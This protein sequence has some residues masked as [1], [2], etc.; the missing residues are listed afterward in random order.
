MTKILLVGCGKMGGALLAGW[1]NRGVAAA[2]V[3]V[4]EPNPVS[5]LPAGLRQV[6]DAAAI[7]AD[8]VPDIVMLAV[9]PQAMDQAAPAYARYAGRACFL[10]IA[11]GKTIAGLNALLG[12]NAAIVRSMPNTPAAV[13][14]GITVC[15]ASATVST[16]QRDAC[17]SR[18]HE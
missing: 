5:D 3:V 6:A 1:I 10:S 8:F 2:N 9:K 13:G 18:R 17:Q 16:G 12:G 14:R 4:V 11:A 7:P 15:C